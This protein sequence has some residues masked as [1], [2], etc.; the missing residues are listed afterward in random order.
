MDGFSMKILVAGDVLGKFS[1]F[2]QRVKNVNNKAG[3]FDFVLCSGSFFSVDDPNSEDSNLVY[4]AKEY[5]L[6]CQVPIFV[7]GP[8]VESQKKFYKPIFGDK[9][10]TKSFEDGYDIANGVTFLGKKGIHTT[11]LGL[12]IIY[13]SGFEGEKSTDFTFNEKDIND[14]IGEASLNRVD[15]LLTTNYPYSV[16]KNSL[17]ITN[18]YLKKLNQNGSILVSK[19]CKNILPRYHFTSSEEKFFEREPFRNHIVLQEKPKLVTRFI[20]IASVDNCNKEK[21]LYAFNI[22]PAI[23]LENDCLLKQPDDTTDNP[24]NNLNF[25]NLLSIKR[26]E[27][28]NKGSFFFSLDAKNNNSQKKRPNSEEH[29]DKRLKTADNAC[30]FCLSSPDVEKHLIISIGDDS[31]LALAKGGLIDRHFLILPIG[32]YRSL[33]EIE[34]NPDLVKVRDEINK[35]KNALIDCF[36]SLEK[37][38]IFFERNFKSGHL[39]L[40][41]IAID[42]E[43]ALVLKSVL[44]NECQARGLSLKEVST[45][46]KFV[47]QIPNNIPYFYIEFLGKR[48]FIGIKTNKG[49]PMQFGRE[50]LA[51]EQVLNLASK[52]DWRNCEL[53]KT[54]SIKLV[55]KLRQEFKNYDFTQ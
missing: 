11:K 13:L 51:N 3:P 7:L 4:I 37:I 1:K 14:L 24:F 41:V 53:D 31:Y 46:S 5:Y 38:P 32:H 8:I 55:E 9:L 45:S 2:Y 49:F 26:Q 22:I 30:W 35:F 19:L 28:M 16:N 48:Y 29:Q 40:Q 50:L 18:E 52:V 54:E 44:E 10:N 20:S 17:S 21:W 25:D 39:Q 42:K 23:R 6:E 33:A 47:D 36:I 15:I 34:H 27:S 12:K 43:K